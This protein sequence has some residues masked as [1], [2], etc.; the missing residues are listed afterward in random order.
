MR[1]C[2]VFDQWIIEKVIPLTSSKTMPVMS[3]RR[4][5]LGEERKLLTPRRSS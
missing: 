5:R 1:K 2:D 3:V 4:R